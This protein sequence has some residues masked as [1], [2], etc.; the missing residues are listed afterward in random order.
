VL[1]DNG[2][3]PSQ[4]K[5]ALEK[6]PHGGHHHAHAAQSGGSDSGDSDDSDS[7]SIPSETAATDPLLAPE[8]STGAAPISAAS[9]TSDGKQKM[10]EALLQ[11]L[12]KGLVVDAQA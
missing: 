8:D 5:S 9:T 2:I 3:D 12:Q 6:L 1:K 7:L 4:F 11:L 10:T